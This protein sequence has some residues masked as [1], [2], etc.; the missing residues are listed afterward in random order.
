MYI[1]VNAVFIRQGMPVTTVS[2]KD[3]EK[4]SLVIGRELDLY[5]IME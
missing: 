1:I 4:C 3:K 2:E 5:G